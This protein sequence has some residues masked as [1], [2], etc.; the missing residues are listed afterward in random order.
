MREI[1]RNGR[2][3][4]VAA[5]AVVVVG[6]ARPASAQ[7]VRDTTMLE[8][9]VVTANRLPMPRAAVPTAV[10]VLDGQDLQE[11]GI[12]SVAEALRDVAGMAIVQN[13]SYGGVTSAF[14]RGGE[15]DHLKVL[16]DGVPV[17]APGGAVD[18]ADLTTDNVERIEIVRG[19]VSVL[20]GSDAV[21]GVVQIF[22]RRGDGPLHG[23]VSLRAGTYTSLD[24]VGGIAGGSKMLDYSFAVS[25]SRTDG[26]YEYN[27][28][29]A[30][31]VWSSAVGL[32]PDARTDAGVTV[33]YGT[34]RY[35]YPTD[36]V[37]A[38]VDAN[39]FQERDQ[40]L[41]GVDA[42]RFLTSALELRGALAMNQ[43]DGSIDDRQDGPADT[44]GFFGYSSV[45]T[46]TR[47]SADI[48][49]NGYLPHAT[50]L[51]IGGTLEWQRER[52]AD[53]SESEFG[54]GISSFEA[55]RTS[56]AVYA[57][58]QVAPAAGLTVTAGSR[59]EDNSAF[60]TFVS[61]RGGASLGVATGLR[62]RASLGRG[63]KEPTFFE[64]FADGPFARGNPALRP[65]RSDSWEAGI[66]QT[67]FE[68]ALVVSSTYFDQRF[69]DLVEYVFAPPVAGDPNYYNVAAATARGVEAEV[70][71]EGPRGL[72]FLGSY[73][74]LQAQVTEAGE[75]P[76]GGLEDGS[77][78]L[79][80]PSHTAR[81]R[82]AK[83]LWQRG[84]V[85]TTVRY[86]GTR[87]DLD[88][89]T[90]PA[91]RVTLPAYV[92]VDL[93]LDL[94]LWEPA[95]GRPSVVGTLRVEN[96][97]DVDY[98]EIQGFRTPGRAVALGVRVGV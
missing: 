37:G 83:R 79:R 16:V 3:W 87:D 8:P 33:R 31:T 57:Q 46:A 52:T 13:G 39:A 76:G 45:R 71:L 68:G 15:S 41:L 38:V 86:T 55:E 26:I 54:P 23:D 12:R 18:L 98:Q 84:V 9:M 21:T 10:T 42:G 32:R 11:Q 95:A 43:M 34:S 70:S 27:N 63:F 47:R 65:E 17:N 19:P 4:A 30:N 94:R 66:E 44:L 22:T 1:R 91:T 85:S 50:T 29:Y 97:L 58:A 49:M 61:Y 89:A 80:R 78:L 82:I 72:R 69:R 75:Q 28:E 73:T 67:L 59:I 53:E 93:A 64:T 7:D 92:R 56:R 96:L 36:G 51:T 48:R 81:A 90:F 14:I 20:Y 25:R 5:A 60:G 62:L 6:G 77:R 88:F 40:F 35:H 74:Y 2:T 24:A